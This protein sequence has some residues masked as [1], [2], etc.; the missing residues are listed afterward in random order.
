MA[1]PYSSATEQDLIARARAG[2]D[3]AWAQIVSLHQ[4]P[5]FRLAYLI[6][7][8]REDA[9]DV[10]QEAFIRAYLKLDQ[11]DDARPLRPWL[12][13]ITANLAR[14]RRRRA[15]RYWHAVRRFLQANQDALAVEPPHTENA[16]A[17]M[18]WQAVRRLPA[19]AR[20]VIYLR[21]FLDLSEAETAQA[22]AIAKGTVKS[23]THRALKK[24]RA[25]IE[26]DYPELADERFAN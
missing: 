2:D 23:R 4:Q 20:E 1:R 5:L 18:L 15:G 21:Y 3:R 24:L 10:A 17:E 25:I 12:L 16:A 11:Y 8:N 7:E 13:G 22:L 26:K 6:T 14:N 9:A 19:A